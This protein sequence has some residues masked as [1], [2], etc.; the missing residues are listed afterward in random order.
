MR[1]LGSTKITIFIDRFVFIV[2]KEWRHIDE[3]NTY[4]HNKLSE[5]LVN[6]KD[7]ILTEIC[8]KLK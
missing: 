6:E 4:F 5:N 1:I 7:K 3:S 2:G 8:A